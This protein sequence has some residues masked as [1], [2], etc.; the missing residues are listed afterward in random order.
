MAR[1][2]PFQLIELSSNN[3]HEYY[4]QENVCKQSNE[5]GAEC[6]LAVEVLEKLELK[7]FLFLS[8]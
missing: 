1:Q 3:L 2:E 5:E 4:T 6:V 8:Q 7:I